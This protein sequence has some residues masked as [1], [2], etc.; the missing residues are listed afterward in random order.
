MAILIKTIDNTE[1]QFD[2]Y[3][4]CVRC[5]G[6]QEMKGGSWHNYMNDYITVCAHGCSDPDTGLKQSWWNP[7]VKID[8]QN[9]LSVLNHSGKTIGY[10]P[11]GQWRSY[12]ES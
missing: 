2:A 7:T 12:R 11:S 5:G 3:Q 8:D 1:E 6:T 9:N 4:G 10:F